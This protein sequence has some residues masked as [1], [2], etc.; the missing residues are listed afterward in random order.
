LFWYFVFF[1]IS[2][3]CSILYELVWL[4]LSMAEFGVNT[5]L[6][7]IVLSAFMGGLGLG[8]WAGGALLRTRGP[9]WHFP[10]L[11]LYAFTELLIGV[12]AILVPYELRLGRTLLES[13][14]L[15][16]SWAY[17]LASGFWLALTLV[18][19]C[20]LMGATIPIAMEAIRRSLPQQESRSFSFLYLANVGG[21]VL[22]AFIPLWLVEVFGFRGT[23][24]AAGF[25]NGCLALAATVLSCRPSHG[26][27]PPSPSPSSKV[28]ILVQRPHRTVLWLLFATGLTSMG[29]EVAW[30]RQFTPYEGTVVYAF[31]TI[32]A[33]YLGATFVGSQIYRYWS[34]RRKSEPTLIWILLGFSA[35]LSPVLANPDMHFPT[36]ARV[37]FGIAP[38]AGLLGLITPMLVDRWSGGDP[39]RAGRAYAVNVLGCIFGPLISGFL[40]LPYASERWVIFIFA[41]PWLLVAGHPAWSSAVAPRKPTL[42]FASYALLP[43]ALILIFNS[44]DY[45]RQEDSR[46]SRILRDHTATVIARGQGMQKQLLVN[47]IG[48]TILTPI[49]KMMAHIPLAMLDRP[50]QNA[51]A[52]CFGMGTSY[53]SLMSWGIPVTAVELVPS[54]PRMFGFFHSD[55]EQLLNSPLSRVVIDDGRRY[56][57]RTLQQYDVIVIDPPPPVDAAASSLLYSRE[58]YSIAK[59]RLRPDGIL[60]QWLPDGDA[61][62]IASVARSFKESFPYVRVFHS[63]AGWGYHFIGSHSPIPTQSAAE[64]VE[65]MPPKAISDLME[66]G[67]EP[68]ATSQFAAVLNAELPID[69]L[70]DEAPGV[71]ALADNRPTNE[72]YILRRRLV[73]K[74]WRY[75]LWRDSQQDAILARDA[76]TSPNTH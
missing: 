16:S 76:A 43:V 1:V 63:V 45:E 57:E 40:L 32:L 18:P 9:R 53:R 55:A 24:M 48:M 69:R 68:D 19:W 49:T 31:A 38:F 47:G 74:K 39:A 22:G 64:L 29:I 11:R 65:R 33:V 62:V 30:I 5:A 41:F 44:K 59:R 66:W 51:L 46:S 12:S 23:L 6:V 37:I 42:Q 70:L 28:P 25:L 17:Y 2:G 13:A 67:P 8:S 21:A 35:V 50:A 10:I 15:S 72:Y 14:G 20:S 34:A 36:L 3:F 60:Q 4:R 7:S 75:L 27:F 73:P 54:V 26:I 52:I 56:L 61:V 71:V 58:F